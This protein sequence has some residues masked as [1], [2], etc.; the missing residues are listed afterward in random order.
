VQFNGNVHSASGVY[1]TGADFA[2]MFEWKDGITRPDDCR[3]YFVTLEGRNIRI[4]TSADDYIL[5]VVSSAPSI[6]ANAQSCGWKGMYLRD[7]W[8]SIIYEWAE[9]R[10]EFPTNNHESGEKQEETVTVSVY[11]PTLNPEYDPDRDYQPRTERDEWAAVGLMGQLIVRDDGSCD[12]DGF[13]SPNDEG[14]ATD[15]TEG[16]RVLERL[17][18]DKV[19]VLIR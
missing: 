9:E 16:Y 6:T 7:E 19:L 10:R 4:A 3:G 1:T 12:Q 13:C 15:S 17:D 11:V 18:T 2:E 8:G 5:G 14:I